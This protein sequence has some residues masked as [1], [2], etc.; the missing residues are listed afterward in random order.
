MIIQ[1]KMELLGE[2]VLSS[3]D[4]P[5][6]SLFEKLE[7]AIC[8]HLDFIAANPEL[9]RFFISELYSRPDRA[10]IALEHILAKVS[11]T[12]VSLQRQIDECAAAGVC[13][14]VDARML[15]L[16]IVSLDIFPILG[17]PMIGVI[18]PGVMDDPER[19]VAERKRENIDTIMRKLRP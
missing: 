7:T 4:A 1:K 11:G 14:S 3:I 10:D 15:M 16:D 6:G 18:I 5:G 9:P 8:R 17:A 19:F 13:R 12:I 2:M